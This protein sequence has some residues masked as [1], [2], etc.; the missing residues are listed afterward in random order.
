MG[1]VF[2]FMRVLGTVLGAG[3]LVA[4]TVT[5]AA[6][7]LPACGLLR[8]IAPTWI[9]WCP[10]NTAAEAE[11]QLAAL[12]SRQADLRARIAEHERALALRQCDVQVP[13]VAETPIPEDIDREA[14]ASRDIGLLEGCWELE[15]RFSTRN[16]QTGVTSQYGVWE[17]CFDANG[18]GREEM[19]SDSGSVCSGPVQGSFD[20]AGRLQI[21]EP[22]D[23]PCSD[24]GFI[25]RLESQCELNDDGTARC[26]VSQPEP[27]GST[28]VEFRRAARGE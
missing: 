3:L 2:L 1:T 26:V 10:V 7:L 14:W 21:I 8:S 6:L 18:L 28:T 23:L 16:Q 15:S 17:M 22:A 19:R 13:K 9:D 24:G 27:G 11:L 12:G 25:F 5:L 4:L 20:S